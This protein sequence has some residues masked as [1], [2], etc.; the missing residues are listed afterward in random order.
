MGTGPRGGGYLSRCGGGRVSQLGRKAGIH[1]TG[2]FALHILIGGNGGAKL[3][4]WGVDGREGEDVEEQK[5]AVVEKMAYGTTGQGEVGISEDGDDADAVDAIDIGDDALHCQIPV[6][7]HK[8]LISDGEQGDLPCLDRWRSRVNRE[9]L[10]VQRIQ[11]IYTNALVSLKKAERGGTYQSESYS[12]NNYSNPPS[13]SHT[14]YT[15]S[16]HHPSNDP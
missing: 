9:Q 6:L 15:P 2:A 1:V 3:R 7:I 10:D 11:V 14:D 12:H 4:G 13:K 5:T 8:R 16:P